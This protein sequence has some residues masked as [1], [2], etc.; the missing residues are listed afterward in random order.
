MA[1]GREAKPSAGAFIETVLPFIKTKSDNIRALLTNKIGSTVFERI[2]NDATCP[3]VF[4]ILYDI[5]P[6]PVKI[7]LK[8]ELFM[9]VCTSNKDKI[10]AVVFPNQAGEKREVGSNREEG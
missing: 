3:Q 2:S 5:L 1:E 8:R 9:Q 6:F 4:S 10:I 7:V